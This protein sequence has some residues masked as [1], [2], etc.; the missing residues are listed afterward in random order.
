M[1]DINAIRDQVK[2]MRSK[3]YEPEYIL[4]SAEIYNA[5]GRRARFMGV[6]LECDNRMKGFEVR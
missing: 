3:Q 1:N 4:V 6:M 5:L 2:H